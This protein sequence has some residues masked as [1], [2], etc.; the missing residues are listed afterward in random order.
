MET[1]MKILVT[2][3]MGAIGSNLSAKLI[4]QGNKVYI[5]DNMDSAYSENLEKSTNL[6]IIKGDICDENVLDNSFSKG[7]D[8]VYHVAANFANQS[9]IDNP[10]KDLNTN[11]IGALKIFEYSKKYNVKKVL[12]TSTSCVY[13][14]SNDPYTESFALELTTPYS[15]S[16]LLAEQYLAFYNSF[17]KLPSIVVRF[18]NNYGPGEYPGR[19]RSVI[20]NF[21][22]NALNG[23]PLKIYGSGEET[24]SFTY[25]S[26][27]VDGAIKAMKYDNGISNEGAS[28]PMNKNQNFIYNIAN[29]IPISIKNLALKI[30]ELCENKA[31]ID[32]LK[33]R[34]WDVLP[35]RSVSIKKAKKS[36]NFN[37]EIDLD[38][39]LEN[40]LAWFK[41]DRFKE[42]NASQKFT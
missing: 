9:S 30:N 23:L 25:V 34:N 42:R 12:Y 18:F 5:L 24:R 35:H 20:P 14:A 36:F 29:P 10:I 22:W 1:K 28:F 39:G 27:T 41:S 4:N 37:P 15:I 33:R 31:G 2:G 13:K 11:G 26:D 19:Y 32:Y 8:Q 40:T 16:K 17:H 38:K 21:F 3:G 6:H 7:F